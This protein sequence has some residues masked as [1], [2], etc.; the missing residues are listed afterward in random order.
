[1]KNYITPELNI[2]LI[3]TE[4]IMVVSGEVNLKKAFGGVSDASIGGVIDF[5][6]I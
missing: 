6:A 1:M 4:D 5:D 2:N 3:S